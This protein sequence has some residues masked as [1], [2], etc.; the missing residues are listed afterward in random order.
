VRQVQ[1]RQLERSRI[2]D[3]EEQ[4]KGK[5]ITSASK[6]E[7]LTGLVSNGVFTSSELP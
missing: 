1:F 6:K 4:E 2:N 3:D 5:N 7:I